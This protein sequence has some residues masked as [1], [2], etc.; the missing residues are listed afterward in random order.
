MAIDI[1]KTRPFYSRLRNMATPIYTFLL[2]G[3]F[4]LFPISKNKILIVSYFGK[5]FGDNG[6]Y[7]VEELLKNEDCKIIWACKKQFMP[8]VP[9]TV[10]TVK[11]YSP[12][13]FYHLATSKIWI[14][15]ARFVL[16]TIKRKHQFYI[17]V[18]HGDIGL[19]RIEADAE[20]A[21]LKSYVKGAKRDS[22]MADII[23]S[24]SKYFTDYCRKYF[25]YNGEIL[26]SGCP[27]NDV[28][29][30]KKELE[31]INKKVR[32]CLHI[33]KDEKILL[34][35][36]TFR[37]DCSLK[38][39]DIDYKRTLV[40]LGKKFG[41]KWKILVRLHPSV[42]AKSKLLKFWSKDVI[43]ATGYQDSQELLIASDAVI[44]DYSSIVFDYSL[45][46]RPAFLF[47]PDYDLYN[48]DR[49]FTLDY[50][51][52]PFTVSRSTKE[53]QKTIQNFSEKKYRDRLNDYL[54]NVVGSKE[55]G[56][57]SKIIANRII[58]EM[59]K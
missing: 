24:G 4:R 40:C 49:G 7:I 48:A 1:I 25:W 39:Y 3:L 45:L 37:K 28:F 9:S 42:S 47:A 14:N 43:D 58:E 26:E 56:E 18:W 8:S 57:A 36:P 44:T 55:K 52:L 46:K 17:Q 21:L 50:F 30:K 2:L 54:K 5:G 6:K 15:N 22:K 34:Y 35:A 33:A 19:K 29:F 59:K 41:G 38:Y 12:L 10:K 51:N 53:L 20:N 11:Y 23:T 13:F 16:G 27:R 32:D 31:R